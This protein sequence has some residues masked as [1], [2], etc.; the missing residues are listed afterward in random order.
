MKVLSQAPH[1]LGMAQK[2]AVPSDQKRV[3]INCNLDV[4]FE[5]N[6]GWRRVV[7]LCRLLIGG[8]DIGDSESGDSFKSQKLCCIFC[9]YGFVFSTHNILPTEQPIV[10][11][12]CSSNSLQPI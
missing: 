4:N 6:A 1:A 7:A 3:S 5:D 2:G 9:Y 12:A 8:S 10:L 11:D